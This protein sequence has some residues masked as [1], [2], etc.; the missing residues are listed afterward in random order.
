MMLTQL[1]NWQKHQ[2]I[3][4]DD[5]IK[6]FSLWSWLIVYQMD[7]N[8]RFALIFHFKYRKEWFKELEQIHFE[9]SFCTQNLKNGRRCR[10]SFMSPVFFCL[11]KLITFWDRISKYQSKVVLK[12]DWNELGNGSA[13]KV[14]LPKHN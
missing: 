14:K 7:S 11:K 5:T 3:K 12:I 13:D 8:Q 1:I 9:W 6:S 4:L 10:L 2:Q